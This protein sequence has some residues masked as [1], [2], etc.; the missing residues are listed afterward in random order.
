M[1]KTLF[2]NMRARLRPAPTTPT[3]R[4][5]V[6]YGWLATATVSL[7]IIAWGLFVL[8]TNVYESLQYTHTVVSVRSQSELANI[9]INLFEKTREA[10]EEKKNLPTRRTYTRNPFAPFEPLDTNGDAL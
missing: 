4:P 5:W 8:Y 6:F 9:N 7:L 2:N 3:V 1:F 10:W